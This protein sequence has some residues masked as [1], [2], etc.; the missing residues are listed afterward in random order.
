MYKLSPSKAHR[1]LT[2]T[3]SLEYDTAFVETPWTIRGNI[4]HEF[5]EMK[6]LDKDTSEYEK[7][8]N[9]NDYEYFLIN[10]Y[11]QAVMNEYNQL[12]ANKM[13]V[14]VKESIEIFGFKF[15]LIQDC[16]LIA[17]WNKTATIIDLKTGNYDISPVNNEQ[18]ILYGYSVWFRYPE[19]ENYRLGIFQKGKLKIHEMTK[20][21]LLDFLI[22][23]ES[24]YD[25]IRRNE[26]TYTPSDKACKYCGNNKKCVARA[27]WILSTK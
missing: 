10:A 14:E 18:L 25:E 3:K 26:L 15:N 27:K 20:D 22:S 21:E 1:Y 6:L 23:K 19:I 11:K 9:F 7:E 2:C 17:F 8:H 5:G 13:Q 4:L 24:K 12:Q 16:L